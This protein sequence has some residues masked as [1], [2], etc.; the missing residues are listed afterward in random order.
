MWYL[1]DQN[2]VHCD[3]AARNLLVS[4]DVKIGKYLT[5]VDQKSLP[6]IILGNRFWT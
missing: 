1:H 3:L 5:K 6:L 4:T 2:I